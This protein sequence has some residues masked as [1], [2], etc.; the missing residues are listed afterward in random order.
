MTYN[1]IHIDDSLKD[2]YREIDDEKKQK[3]EGLFNKSKSYFWGLGH[4]LKH[5]KWEVGKSLVINGML[6]PMGLVSL[7]GAYGVTATS[8]E[9]PGSNASLAEIGHLGEWFPRVI[10]YGYFMYADSIKYPE[11]HAYK[12]INDIYNRHIRQAKDGEQK[13]RLNERKKEELKQ[14]NY[15][16]YLKRLLSPLNTA[17]ISSSS[18]ES[19]KA[20]DASPA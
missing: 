8:L 16:S 6:L 7:I 5:H 19:E 12:V 14:H 13:H 1:S 4:H 9:D 20:S 2:I 11:V 17:E 10:V 3:L 18:E 15:Q